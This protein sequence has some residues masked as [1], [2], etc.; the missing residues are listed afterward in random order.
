MLYRNLKGVDKECLIC[1]KVISA[2]R[3]MCKNCFFL[4]RKEYL[5]CNYIINNYIIYN[6]LFYVATINKLKIDCY[7]S[8]SIKNN[9]NG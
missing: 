9:K 5:K 1:G 2:R 3:N 8:I 4:Y 6:Y 7:L